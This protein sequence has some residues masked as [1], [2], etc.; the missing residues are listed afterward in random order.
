[1]VIIFDFILYMLIAR[2][3][4]DDFLRLLSPTMAK[5][6][7]ALTAMMPMERRLSSREGTP[8]PSRLMLSSR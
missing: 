6:A 4:V 3:Y 7:T 5:P 1:M 8:P 2:A